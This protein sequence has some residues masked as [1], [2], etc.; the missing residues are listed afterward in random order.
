MTYTRPVCISYSLEEAQQ[1]MRRSGKLS[2]VPEER[3]P[4]CYEALDSLCNR[5]EIG[6]YVYRD[7]TVILDIARK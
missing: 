1:Y 7:I 6:G 2:T 3:L 5:L 4:E